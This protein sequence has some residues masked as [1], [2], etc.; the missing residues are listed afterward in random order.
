MFRHSQGA[1][2]SAR[3]MADLSRYC[4]FA[5]HTKRSD[6]H[7]CLPCSREDDR[8]ARHHPDAL[9]KV[10]ACLPTHTPVSLTLS[11]AAWPRWMTCSGSSGCLLKC[12]PPAPDLGVTQPPGM[13]HLVP[14]II[15]L[16]ERRLSATSFHFT[17]L[18]ALSSP[19]P[20]GPP[21]D[22]AISRTAQEVASAAFP[23]QPE[24][25]HLE[26]ALKQLTRPGH[27]HHPRRRLRN[28]SECMF[29][30]LLSGGGIKWEKASCPEFPPSGEPQ[31]RTFSEIQA[32]GK[33]EEE[34]VGE[35]GRWGVLPGA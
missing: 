22:V 7:I 29:S 2:A 33:E 11:A 23:D 34:E 5:K 10:L 18:R 15:L 14:C 9:P 26:P 20:P 19:T 16:R 4:V 31:R 8:P 30:L 32:G 28:L 3:P 17:S 12:T 21:R 6:A 24:V 13:R 35:G 27:Q 25:G 1:C